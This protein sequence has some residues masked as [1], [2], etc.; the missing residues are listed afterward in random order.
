MN[1]IAWLEFELAYFEFAVQYFNHY[2]TGP[3]SGLL[4]NAQSF[5]QVVRIPHKDPLWLNF[6]KKEEND[7]QTTHTFTP[8]SVAQ[9]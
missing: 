9:Y 8:A 3:F 1:V 2:I 5:S 6:G 7:K 4:C